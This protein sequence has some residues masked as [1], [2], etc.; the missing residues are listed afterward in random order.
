MKKRGWLKQLLWRFQFRKVPYTGGTEST[1]VYDENGKIIGSFPHGRCEKCD[2]GRPLVECVPY[3][4]PCNMNEQ[5]IRKF[6]WIRIKDWK[7][8]FVL[9][10]H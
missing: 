10:G 7:A 3:T 8:V 5:L 6:R 4:C 2:G 9:S 1:L